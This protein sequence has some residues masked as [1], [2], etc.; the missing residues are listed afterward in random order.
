VLTHS[1]GLE[2]KVILINSLT[3]DCNIENDSCKVLKDGKRDWATKKERSLLL[4]DSYIRLENYNKA[5]RVAQCGSFLEFKRFNDD[6]IKLNKANF[7]KIRLC[8]MCAWR[9]SLKIFGQVSKI[10]NE[11]DKLNN[12]E[13][14]FLTLTIKN[15]KAEALNNN[16]NNIL[17]GFNKLMKNIRVKG[18]IDGYFRGLEITHNI[19][20]MSVS[21][22][23]FHPHIHAILCVKSSYFTYK[24]ISQAEWTELWKRA[25]NV[26][27]DVIVD[28]RKFKSR[29]GVAEACKYTVKDTDYL[30]E[31][32][33]EITDKTVEILDSAL[34]GRRLVA[35]GGVLRDL[36]KKLNLDD[37]LDGDLI[38]TDNDELREDIDYII[39]RYRWNIGYK[40]YIRFE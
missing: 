3:N 18:S 37:V 25:L 14:I 28:V 2:S 34:T 31:Y 10:L 11:L 26:N 23:T 6:N 15:C 39:E 4:F 32:D 27:Y 16:I 35:F 9:R 22:D 36:H 1:E 33:T 24:Y 29:K 20:R 21:Y 13:Y 8:P 12:Y 19:D 5:S 40:Q 38:N 7:C 30:L 17:Y